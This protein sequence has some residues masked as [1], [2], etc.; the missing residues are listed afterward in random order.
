MYLSGAYRPQVLSAQRS[1]ILRPPGELWVYD[2]FKAAMPVTWEWN[3]HS[4]AEFPELGRTG[5]NW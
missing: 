2:A 3:F 5:S 4:A 1:V